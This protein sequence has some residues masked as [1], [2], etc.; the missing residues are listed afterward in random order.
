MV[1]E[2]LGNA[3]RHARA[4]RISLEVAVDDRTAT[5]TVDDDGLGVGAPVRRSGLANLEQ[6]ARARGGSFTIERRDPGTR[7]I[8]R[9]PLAVAASQESDRPA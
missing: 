3:V 1:R 7:A 9:V 6:K 8:W 4:D 2:L 5:V